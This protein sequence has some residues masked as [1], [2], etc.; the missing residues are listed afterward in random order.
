MFRGV[1]QKQYWH[2]FFETRRIVKNDSGTSQKGQLRN[3]QIRGE[4][5]IGFERCLYKQTTKSIRQVNIF[6]VISAIPDQHSMYKYILKK[7]YRF[8]VFTMARLVRAALE[9]NT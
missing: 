9:F 4:Q 3:L 1:I 6:S 2:S 8:Q 7:N 5:Y